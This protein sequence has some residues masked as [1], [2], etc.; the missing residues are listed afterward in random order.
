[1]VAL[2]PKRVDH[3]SRR[4]QIARAVCELIGRHGLDAAT[5]REVAAQAGVSMGAVQRCFRTREEMLVFAQEH[6]NQQVTERALARIAD[7][8]EPES[9]A[10]LVEQ[11]VT[12]MLAVDDGDLLEARVWIAFVAQSAVD[13]GLAAVQRGFSEGLAELLVVLLRTGQ[14]NGQVRPEVDVGREADALITLT[15]GLT[16]QVL[17]GRHTPES[18]RAAV[19]DRIVGLWTSPA[20]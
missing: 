7:S 13:P 15:D 1:M 20:G 2:M 6:V 19:H 3:D 14:G 17:L 5:L 11:T 4:R 18:A 10:T 16:V 9:I 8:P 12:A